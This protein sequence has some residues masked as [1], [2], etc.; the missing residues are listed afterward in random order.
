MRLDL[1]DAPA[2][3]A[4]VVD[5]PAGTSGGCPFTSMADPRTYVDGSLH[6]VWAGLRQENPVVWTA[7]EGDFPGYWSVTGHQEAREIL[8]DHET[9]S[10]EYG[11]ILDSVGAGGDSAGGL[12]ITLMDPPD[13]TEIRAAVAPLLSAP[14]ARAAEPV[15]RRRIR[16][17]VAPWLAGGTHDVAG[18]L[19]RLSAL[20]FGEVIGILPEHW[21]D[22]ARWTTASIAPSDPLVSR[23]DP[24]ETVLADAHHHLF[25]CFRAA[26]DAKRHTPGDDIVTRLATTEVGGRRLG[27]R[28]QLL[29]LYSTVLGAGTTTPHV[30]A[31]LLLLCARRP[32]LWDRVRTGEVQPRLLVDEAVRWICPTNHLVRRVNRDTSVAGRAMK[33]GDWVCLW[34]AAANRDPGR[35]RQPDRFDAERTGAHLGYGAGPHIC[36]GMHY[37]RVALRVLVEELAV[38]VSR[39]TVTGPVRHL[40]STFI[41]G[42]SHMTMTMEVDGDGSPQN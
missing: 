18:D 6:G 20:A 31:H 24:P 12:T 22:L 27:E 2:A 19:Q 11:T 5:A 8:R 15:I 14:A 28:E 29:N 10:S 30:A 38:S 35:H 7:P 34:T 39:F 13:H 3:D 36:V 40:A 1:A 41:N 4:P 32:A 23:G 16:A 25:R 37:A 42:I 17:L 21:D 26:I 33:A 9:F